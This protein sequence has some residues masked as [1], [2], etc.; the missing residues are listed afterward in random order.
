MRKTKEDTEKTK[1]D[2]MRVA[3]KVFN[4]KGYSATRLEDVAMAANVTRGAIYYHFGSKAEIFK[5]IVFENKEQ[6]MKLLTESFDNYKGTKCE[7]LQYVFSTYLCRVEED[8]FFRDVEALLFKT[9][10]TGELEEM[11][12]L[13]KMHSNKG[14]M[15][16]IKTIKEGKIDGSIRS[17]IDENTFAFSLSGYFYGTMALWHLNRDFISLK[18]KSKEI[19]EYIFQACRA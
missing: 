8:E 16:L 1:C 10:L 3:V 15:N 14:L 6:T 2:L 18:E 5:A 19:S 12:N 17:D 7:A 9:E 13:F 4:E 11:E